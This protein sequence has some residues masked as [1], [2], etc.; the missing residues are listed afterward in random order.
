M[1]KH[2][3]ASV[4]AAFLSM[5]SGYAEAAPKNDVTCIFDSMSGE[6]REIAM[7]MLT[8]GMKSHADQMQ[9]SNEAKEVEALLDDAHNACLDLYPWTSGQSGNAIEYA[10]NAIARDSITDVLKL[11][12]YDSAIINGYFDA[13]RKALAKYRSSDA[14]ETDAALAAFLKE[15]GW[16]LEETGLAKLAGIYLAILW[17]QEKLRG[18][19]ARGVYFTR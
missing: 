14:V 16:D 2:F 13:N 1:G 7:V 18:G 9:G 6:D 10:M 8:A 3:H 12:K 17:Q 15:Q 5:S 19:F 11:G 4:L